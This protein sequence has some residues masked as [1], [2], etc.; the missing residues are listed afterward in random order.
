MTELEKLRNG[1]AVDGMHP[2]LYAINLKAHNLSIDYSGLLEDDPRRQEILDELLGSHGQVYM[3]G[4]IYFNFGVNT[5]LGDGFFANN[6]F[7]VSDDA[8]VR[9][10]KRVMCGPH[11][12]LITATHPYIMEERMAMTDSQ[13]N[14]FAPLLGNPITIEDGVFLGGGVIVL[15]GVT[16]GRGSVIGAGSVVTRDIPPGVIAAGNPC[17]VIREIGERDSIRDRVL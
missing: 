1:Y 7:H 5:H 15:G 13:G 12:S 4:P 8:E 11:V 3:R 14:T 6:D 2:E 9:I 16:I 17:R 10:G